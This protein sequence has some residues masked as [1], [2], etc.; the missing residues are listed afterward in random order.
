MIRDLARR[1][2]NA[3]AFGV[4]TAPAS[5]A[6]GNVAQVQVRL[7]QLEVAMLK[8]V[9]QRGFASGLPT[10]TPVVVLFQGGDRSNGAVMGSVA[11]KT[12]PA[13]AGPEDAAVYGYGFQVAIR[14]DGVHIEAPDVFVAGNL[15]VTGEVT[16]RADGGA[17]T[18]SQHRHPSTQPPVPNT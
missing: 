4:T 11:P 15:H 16:G 12:R 10:G 8:L 7:S 5:T 3:M 6:D 14:A 18:L 1:V 2:R 13:L 9:E 17:V